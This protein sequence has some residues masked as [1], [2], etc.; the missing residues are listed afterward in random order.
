MRSV[1]HKTQ[2]PELRHRTAPPHGETT[3]AAASPA[4]WRT[5]TLPAFANERERKSASRPTCA[6]SAWMR[7]G[8]QPFRTVVRNLGLTPN[9]VW[10]LTQTDEEWSRALNVALTATRR[11]DLQHGTNAAYV[12]GCVCSECLGHQRIRMVRHQIRG[13]REL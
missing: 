6:N 8:G 9:Q 4:A 2:V 12:D 10:G 13:R 3:A 11:D 5:A 7:P 1:T